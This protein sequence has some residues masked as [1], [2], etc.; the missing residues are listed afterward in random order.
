[1]SARSG[2]ATA[3]T[4]ASPVSKAPIAPR[5]DPLLQ[6]RQH[7]QS[8]VHQL[9][10]NLARGSVDGERITPVARAGYT[11]QLS[12]FRACLADLNCALEGKSVERRPC[13]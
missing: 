2:S 11:G 5:N 7:L 6:L 8:Y 10:A 1:M 13:V 3:R 4:S 9:E 12:A